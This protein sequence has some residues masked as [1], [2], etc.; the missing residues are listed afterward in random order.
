MA[1]RYVR[2]V[3]TDELDLVMD[4]GTSVH[5]YGWRPEGQARAIVQIT[6]G[7]AEHSGRYARLAE[8]LV[9]DGYA[10]W[11]HDHRGHG[12]T[13]ASES[14]LGHFADANGFDLLV[15][16]LVAVR[17]FVAKQQ[18]TDE[19]AKV[20]LFA[21]SMGTFV[22]QAALATRSDAHWNA[23]ILSGSDA[24]RGKGVGALRRV[25]GL[26]RARQG[27]RGRSAL[28]DALAFRPYNSAF[29]PTRTASDWLSRDQSEVDKFVQDPLT[30]FRLTNQAWVD[31]LDARLRV[32]RSGF[33]GVVS[34]DLFLLLLAGE[35]DPVGRKGVGVRQLEAQLRAGGLSNVETKQYPGAR[36]ELI[37][38]V[39]RDEVH[40]DVL[41]F[42]AGALK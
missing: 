26:D 13:A 12:R 34:K 28:I 8:V 36:H 23:I 35:H 22:T 24:P 17:D 29:K 40:Q 15:S 9:A 18:P 10:V 32:G 20:G 3:I 37:N 21:H 11:S 16:D 41:A 14:D 2:P 4:D 27:K 39:N 19:P 5:V 25:A 33:E 6:H 42:F 1:R 30:G 31:F 7:M 38:E